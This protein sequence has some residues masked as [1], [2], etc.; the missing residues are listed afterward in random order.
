MAEGKSGKTLLEVEI[1]AELAAEAAARGVD[2]SATLEE[3]L[4]RLTAADRG[5]EW[6]RRNLGAVEAW[7][8]L[9]DKDG[10]WA[11]KYRD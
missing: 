4:T 2:L 7:N 3:A 1:D 10:L 11:D 6:R 9:V 5:A 8:K